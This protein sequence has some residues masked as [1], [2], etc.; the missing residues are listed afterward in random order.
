MIYSDSLFIFFM[1]LRYLGISIVKWITVFTAMSVMTMYITG[2]LRGYL[3]DIPIWAMAFAVAYGF[4]YWALHPTI[5]GK[6]ELIQ[7]IIIWVVVTLTLEAFYEI[8]SIGQIVFVYGPDFFGQYL[9]EIA[10]IFLAA[11][12]IHNKKIRAAGSEGLS[13]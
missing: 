1:W 5:P 4:A 3:L 13:V 6:R 7:L 9:F 8:L 2:G 11:R 10:A 12:V